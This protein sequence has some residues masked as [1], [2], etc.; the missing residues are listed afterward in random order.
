MCKI[1]II[2]VGKLKEDFWVKAKDEYKTRLCRFCDLEIIELPDTPAP[3]DPSDAQVENVLK[4]EGQRILKHI[5]TPRDTAA[6]CVEGKKLSSEGFAEYI[7]DK[8]ITFI[9]GG[10]YGLSGEVKA[11]AGA[12]LSFSDMTF[13]HQLTRVILLEQIYRGYKIINNENYHK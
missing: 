9:I 8:N 5:K 1:K 2:C 10:S 4:I 11:V 3:R 6:L 12:G 7:K 13:P